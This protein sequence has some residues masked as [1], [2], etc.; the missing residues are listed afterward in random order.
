MTIECAVVCAMFDPTRLLMLANTNND[1]LI[2]I[3]KL[4]K[5]PK[6]RTKD[7]GNSASLELSC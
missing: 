5:A 4:P 1:L 6:Q 2:I 3:P 7:R